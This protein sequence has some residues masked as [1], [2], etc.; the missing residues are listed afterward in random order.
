MLNMIYSVANSLDILDNIA[1]E[2]QISGLFREWIL[3]IWRIW[4]ILE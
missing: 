2:I 3:R 4:K 1:T